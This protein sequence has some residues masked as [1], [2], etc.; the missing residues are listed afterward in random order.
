MR[1]RNNVRLPA[2]LYSIHYYLQYNSNIIY[3]KDKYNK[4]SYFHSFKK[5]NRWQTDFPVIMW[6]IPRQ[7]L[8]NLVPGEL[9]SCRKTYRRLA[10]QEHVGD[11]WMKTYA[12][13]CEWEYVNDTVVTLSDT[14]SHT[15]DP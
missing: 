8:T 9:R 3:P 12:R 14:N 4:V 1:V 5:I 7:G 2:H 11:P 15:I 6:S 10:L 13:I